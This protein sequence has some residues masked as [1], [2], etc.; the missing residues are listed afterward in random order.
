MPKLSFD[1]FLA[2]IEAAPNFVSH[3]Q[4]LA[5]VWPGLVVSDK[6]ISQR[7]KLLRDALGDSRTE[8][9]YIGNRRGRGYRIVAD[10]E[11]LQAAL[12]GETHRPRIST[13]DNR[14]RLRSALWLTVT[15]AAA[16]LSG[17]A[18]WWM[19]TPR[20]SHSVE[21]TAAEPRTAVRIAVLPFRGTREGGD[22]LLGDSIAEALANR[23][24]VVSHLDVI[25]HDST[26]R[27]AREYADS[28]EVARRLGTNFVLDGSIE[29]DRGEASVAVSLLE[30]ATGSQL[31]RSTYRDKVDQ[32]LDIEE[33]IVR[34]TTQAL[35]ARPSAELKPTRKLT[36]NVEAYLA[37]MRGRRLLGRWTV[38][39]ARHAEQAF[40]AAIDFDPRF[41]AAFAS[42][43]EARL[44]IA[45]RTGGAGNQGPAR[46]L[47]A[48]SPLDAARE[49]NRSLIDR[50]LE[51]DPGCG[52]AYFARAIWAADDAPGRAEDFA[53]GLELDPS[54]GRA[55]A[56]YAEFLDDN[57]RR[58]E[59]ERL[60]E[61]ALEIDP[62]S[63]RAHFWRVM[64]QFPTNAGTI[65][66][67]LK[68]VLDIDPDYQPALQ[69]YAKRR[70]MLH[71]ELTEAIE[72]IERALAKD[73]GNPWLTHT[74]TALYLD[75]A[76]D[77]AARRALAATEW[78]TI[79]GQLLVYLYDRDVPKA[80]EAALEDGAFANGI[81]E[82][83][84]VYEAARDWAL[85]TGETDATFDYLVQ[86]TRLYETG[87]DVSNFRVVPAAAHL[88]LEMGRTA[89]AHDLLMSTIQWIDDYHLPQLSTV[90]ALRVKATSLLL[91]GETD[92][93]LDALDASFKGGDYLQWWYTLERDPVWKPLHTNERFV[94][95]SRRVQAHIDGQR[96]LLT[97]R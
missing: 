79:G 53:R 65:E 80:G 82:T 13:T 28:L 34:R 11:D 76:D 19:S 3:Q 94:A 49:A 93:A 97:S 52:A 18:V 44:L 86:R 51:V 92:L 67:G 71:G 38:I 16:G 54:N 61:R 12:Q 30:T 87:I 68:A 45:D 66:A 47:L 50:A 90:F 21:T 84:G 6:T 64:R 31:W 83:W 89:D 77:A 9:R 63:P 20:T 55:I 4:L 22:S 58:S 60:L 59:A 25:G 40:E 95:I 88:L 5:R 91:L 96:A 14:R 39:D 43:Y 1:L 42:L 72:I 29:Q 69:R 7:V 85:E 73:P 70:W 37:Y 48:N 81:H 74:A 41:A 46:S 75:L 62:I 15:V 17:V 35:Q 2:L 57:G 78:P 33:D 23:L 10:V 24:A 32:I 36:S 56:A 27:L 26:F 8:R